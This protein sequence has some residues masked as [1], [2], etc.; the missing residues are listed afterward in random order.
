MFN[1]SG[2]R[3]VADSLRRF[4][5]AD[6]SDQLLVGVFG[7][8]DEADEAR[9]LEAQWRELVDGTLTP[10]SMLG[11]HLED[12]DVAKLNKIHPLELERSTLIDAITPRIATKTCNE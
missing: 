7:K 3:N 8:S 11:K 10:V 2:S 1:I 6:D 4:G 5:I 9:K 12:A